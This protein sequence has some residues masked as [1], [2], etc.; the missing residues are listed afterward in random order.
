MSSN[1][2]SEKISFKAAL[3]SST[4]LIPGVSATNA[5]LPNL[6]H[7]F[8]TVAK[9]LL[10][11]FISLPALPQFIFLLLAPLFTRAI[12]KRNTILLGTGLWTISGILPIVLNDFYA[13]LAS[14]LI[15]G[16]SLGLIQPIGTA[17]ISD[18]YSGNAKNTMLG[19][20]S[21][22]IGIAGS[23]FTYIIGALIADNW[24]HAFYIYLVGILVFFVTWLIIPNKRDTSNVPS[25][26][27]DHSS[28]R[29]RLGKDIIWWICLTLFFNLA[30]GGVGFEFNL[31]VVEQNVSD[32]TGA[33]NMM[34][35]YSILGLITGLLFGLYMKV[36]R[37]LGGI[38]A[39]SLFFLG[40]LLVAITSSVL[41]YYIA[42]VL[43]GAGF[44]LFMPYMFASVNKHTTAQNSALATSAT[45]AA[46][47]LGNF[48]APYI[49]AFL[50]QIFGN[51]SS[52]FS[53]WFSSAFALLL[54]LGLIVLKVTDRKEA[55][56]N[57][58]TNC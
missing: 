19:I 17:M 43:L 57:I 44:G 18:Y 28:G 21:S 35:V 6:Q 4:F 22:V 54:V 38:V 15:L 31:A 42:V 23:I 51:N 34:V 36:F 5:L 7:S 39:G 16:A 20:Q 52:H 11:S 55:K 10:Q 56:L 2:K 12:G 8:P 40:N 27:K 58:V 25:D 37:N 26:N 46:A 45:T 47:S 41:T 30:Q 9:P 3:I 29:G 49:Y 1:A 32:A 14:R 13:I 50:A 24:K 53:F 33:A 48:V